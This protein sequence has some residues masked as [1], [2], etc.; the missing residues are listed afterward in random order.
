MQSRAVDLS[1]YIHKDPEA[2]AERAA[3]MLATACDEAVEERGVF[4]IALSGGSTPIPLFRMLAKTDWRERLPWD[5][6]VFFWADERCVPPESQE[7]NYGMARRELL[8]HV[9]A[10][11]F[12]RMRGE[13]EPVE[14]ARS[15]EKKLHEEF[16]IGPHGTPRF[17]FILL[18]MGAD[19]HAA[20]IFP[21]SPVMQE[22]DRW[23]ADVY[24]PER[25]SNRLTLTLPV[26]NNARLCMFLVSGAEK[27]QALSDAMNLLAEP[28]LP[29]QMIRPAAGDLIWIVD[30][31]AARGA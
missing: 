9:P 10:T 26:I 6:M 31:A 25:R 5:K 27:Y 11:H 20:S 24:V 12:Y 3:H 17:D 15:Y 2:M 30:E 8:S 7:S 22:K 18:G 1:L 16:E 21:K 14:A 29:A 23:V 19:G 4:R 13:E 28:K